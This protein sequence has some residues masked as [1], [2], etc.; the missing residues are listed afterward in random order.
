M[1]VSIKLTG[2]L[3]AVILFACKE[4]R[5]SNSV[6]VVGEFKNIDSILAQ[7]PGAFGTDSI[8]IYLYEVPFG[9]EGQPVQLD[10]TFVYKKNTK[11]KLKAQATKEAVF[12]VMIEKGPMM[13]SN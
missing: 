4:K 6:E 3:L 5:I 13:P 11:F 7:Y 1:K 9:G 10:S 12:D 2:V 8:K